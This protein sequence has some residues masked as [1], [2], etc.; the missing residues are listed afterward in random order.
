[1]SDSRNN[2]RNSSDDRDNR[3]PPRRG[4]GKPFFKK[5]VDKIKT[6]NLTVDYKHPE[7]LR[8]FVTEK[9]KILPRRITGTSAKNQRR[10]VREIKKA[11]YLALIPM[12]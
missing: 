3:R 11:R 1:M 12:G 5:K 6:Q 4:G 8:R 10:L 2:D 7:V 9:G